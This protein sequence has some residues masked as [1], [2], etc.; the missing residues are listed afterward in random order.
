MTVSFQELLKKYDVQVPR[1]TSYPTVPAWTD[2]PSQEQWF[3]E[4]SKTLSGDEASWALYVHIPFCE[5]LCTF[6]GC[7]TII[8]RNHRQEGDYVDL[9]LKEFSI[10]LARSP[11]L[12]HKPLRQ[13][14]LGGGSPTFLSPESLRKLVDG[15][16][17]KIK[18]TTHN[19]E[20]SIE[21]DPRRT[22][23]AQLQALREVGFDRVSLG[24]QDFNKKVQALINRVQPFEQTEQITLISRELGYH[25]VNFDLI[26]GLPQQDLESM[27]ITVEQTLKL[28]P[29]RIALY[30]FALVPWI[31]PAQRLFK[32]SDL[33][34]TEKK[35]E[36]Y[37]E[38]RKMFIAAGYVEIGM[39]HFALPSDSMVKAQERGE[40]HRNFMG[41]TD[42]KTDLLLG[43]GVS[44][45]SESHS[46]FHQNEKL[47]PK[48]TEALDRQELATH[49]GHI[50]NAED[51]VVR[52]RILQLMTQFQLLVPT[53]AE[54]QILKE[55]MKGL[56]AD[57]LIEW[58]S[59]KLMIK[60]AGRP[61]IRNICSF[62][63]ERLQKA[64]PATD[65]SK[66]KLFSKSI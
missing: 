51:Q 21:V 50:L 46:M 17:S 37:E 16:F 6:C 45:I 34:E 49:R 47:L 12:G 38:A 32:D 2:T 24:V 27:K 11:E 20:A 59:Q 42:F 26:Y 1:Y 40:L 56:E 60:T 39:D 33:P 63:D 57:G 44:S 55:R 29:D 52:H 54:A 23:R 48:F 65:P 41:Y 4:I 66:N 43:L 58:S 15:I 13:I 61:F 7:N 19:F 30:S 53:E 62:V 22:T 31:K 5:T 8:T 14:H 36:L 35:R 18:K 9:L 3:A 25:S 28:R 10:Y 64:T